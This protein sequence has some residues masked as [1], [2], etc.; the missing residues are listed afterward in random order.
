M[1]NYNGKIQSVRRRYDSLRNFIG[2][3]EVHMAGDI[4]CV[5]TKND[6]NYDLFLDADGQR[7]FMQLYLQYKNG[8]KVPVEPNNDGRINTFDEI[9]ALLNGLPEGSNLQAILE[10]INTDGLSEEERAALDDL[11][12]GEE[13]SEEEADADWQE[14]MHNAGLDLGEEPEGNGGPMAAEEE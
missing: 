9:I 5:S 11:V 13:Y 7:T 12:N 14:A 2:R 3:N 4:L 6:E 1:K 10:N 8:G